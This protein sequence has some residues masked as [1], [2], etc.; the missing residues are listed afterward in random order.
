MNE[1]TDSQAKHSVQDF[2]TKWLKG[3]TDFN[4]AQ[5]KLLGTAYWLV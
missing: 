5:P 1:E 3:L 2:V 4:T